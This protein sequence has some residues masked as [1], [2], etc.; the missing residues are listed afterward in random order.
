MGF[1][2]DFAK[3]MA[4]AAGREDQLVRASALGLGTAIVE[5][6]PVGDPSQW[7]DPAPEGYVGGRFRGNW[8]YGAGQIN[9]NIDSPID[10]S[11]SSSVGRIAVG[12]QGWKRG[13]SIFITNSLPYAKRLE[14]EAWSN[15]SK[16]GMV[17]I[18]VMEFKANVK[19][20]AASL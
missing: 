18:S 2:Q 15:Q 12:L 20:Q 7:K 4:R 13:Q 17:R 5:K 14:Y 9:M 16:A 1:K 10:A 11:G 19:K 6:S 3:M 8:Q